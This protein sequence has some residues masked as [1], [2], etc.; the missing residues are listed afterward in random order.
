MDPDDDHDDLEYPE[1]F[2]EEI[3]DG[4]DYTKEE[5]DIP[6]NRGLQMSRNFELDDTVSR[7][8]NMLKKYTQQE[9]VPIA[10]FLTP[11]KFQQFL[12]K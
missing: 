6:D 12:N 1:H 2:E 10:Q 4:Y 7:T 9:A 5:Q 8:L 11:E 3:P